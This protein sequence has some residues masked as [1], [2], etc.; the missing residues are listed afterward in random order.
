MPDR[1]TL[2][3][4]LLL[5]ALAFGL[6]FGTQAL[7]GGGASAAKPAATQS[8][9]EPVV[10]APGAEA[11]LR[12]AAAG[13]VPALRD[14]RRPRKRRVRARKPARKTRPSVQRTPKVSPPP[15]TP[16]PTAQPVPTAA[17]RY[18]PPAPRRVT[19][20]PAAPKPTPAPT[21]PPPPSGEF[22]TT[23]DS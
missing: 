12:L 9:P 18:V 2:R 19:P 15:M 6:T 7:M 4:T 22:D 1:L 16:A 17:P 10:D 21:S 23:G 11:D 20:K 14:P 8:A 13:T 5:A 3:T